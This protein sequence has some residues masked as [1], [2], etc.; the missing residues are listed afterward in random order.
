MFFKNK[1]DTTK[2]NEKL[3]KLG[4]ISHEIE[5]NNEYQ[6][7]GYDAKFCSKVAYISVGMIVI[8]VGSFVLAP[9]LINHFHFLECGETLKSSDYENQICK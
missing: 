2:Q 9:I 7:L 8:L 5:F 3:N 1:L 4:L 6:S